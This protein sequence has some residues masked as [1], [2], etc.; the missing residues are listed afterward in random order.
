MN[1]VLWFITSAVV[2]LGLSGCAT[3]HDRGVAY[4]KEN[5]L[6][7]AVTTICYDYWDKKDCPMGTF[8]AD[9]DVLPSIPG[10]SRFC[11]GFTEVGTKYPAGMKCYSKDIV[12]NVVENNVSE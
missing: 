1:K 8:Q 4:I 9:I 6:E 10:T 5:H 3:M 12:K 7:K 11:F 2:L